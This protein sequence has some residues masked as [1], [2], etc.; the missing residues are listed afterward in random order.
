MLERRDRMVM[1]VI[2]VL[3]MSGASCEDS[4]LPE[5]VR[6]LQ[7]Q[8]SALLEEFTLLAKNSELNA[9][10]EE[11]TALRYVKLSVENDIAGHS[12]S[13]SGI[14]WWT[15]QNMLLTSDEGKI[16]RILSI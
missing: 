11:L 2:I 6:T 10:R 4:S 16:K 3:L 9:L 5:T 15:S 7:G 12:K 8:V 13:W 14:D 1:W